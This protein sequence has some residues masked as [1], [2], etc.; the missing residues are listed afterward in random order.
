MKFVNCLEVERVYVNVC[1]LRLPNGH[2]IK[3]WR[4]KFFVMMLRKKNA[5]KLEDEIVIVLMIL[6]LMWI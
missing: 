1:I 4:T 5:C 2:W 3:Q 6:L